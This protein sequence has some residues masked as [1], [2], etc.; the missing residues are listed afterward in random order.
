MRASRF[1]CGTMK[2]RSI[3]FSL[4]SITLGVALA[5]GDDKAAGDG[6]MPLFDGKTL[7]AFTQQ[8]GKAKY[9]LADGVITGHAVANT[10][11]SF[12]ATNKEYG[13]FELEFEFMADPKM[14]SGVQIR[15]HIYEEDK[16]YDWKGKEVKVGKGRFHG[17][18]VE[19]EDENNAR[20]WSCGIY[21]EG[22]R[23]WLFPG[24]GGGDGKAFGVA[25][26]K[27]WKN[28][29]WNKVRVVAKGDHIQ[30]WLNGEPRA[31]LTDA[32]TPKGHIALQVHGVGGKDP[33]GMKVSWRNLRIREL[34]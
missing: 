17:Y 3:L 1:N 28:G 14:N 18:Q 33:E 5:A 31:D 20:G 8:G 12:L 9:E 7:E 2:T 10:P 11:N 13:D 30:T 25:G 26:E 34:E 16:T 24:A 21:D 27:L 6:W 32:M 29:E 15:S 22:R 19:L 4:V 23:G